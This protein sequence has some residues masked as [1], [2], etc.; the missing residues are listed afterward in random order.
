M[1]TLLIGFVDFIGI[2]HNWV[3]IINTMVAKILKLQAYLS[4][5]LLIGVN[6]MADGSNFYNWL[7][8]LD[9]K[10]SAV[11][12]LEVNGKN[13]EKTEKVLYSLFP[14]GSCIKEV[15]HRL[16][17]AVVGKDD[18]YIRIDKNVDGFNYIELNIECNCAE[19][20]F[21][22]DFI[23]IFKDETLVK[24]LYAHSS[25]EMEG[26]RRNPKAAT[27]SGRHANQE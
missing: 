18:C 1:F 7:D 25:G 3:F 4:L 16:R 13:Q 11:L 15:E 19:E 14:V 2:A 22:Y 27:N 26:S 24:L 6:L 17:H 10:S 20:W 9:R 12:G 23:F 8:C 5:F 21:S